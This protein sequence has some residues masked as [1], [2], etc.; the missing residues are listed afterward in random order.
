LISEHIFG[1]SQFADKV[2]TTPNFS[3]AVPYGSLL[4]KSINISYQQQQQAC[5]QHLERQS[6][7]SFLLNLMLRLFPSQI[8][9]LDYSSLQAHTH[10]HTHTHQFTFHE[11]FIIGDFPCHA[12]LC[13]AM[14]GCGSKLA[15][16]RN[17]KHLTMLIVLDSQ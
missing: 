12:L 17:V 7:A 15:V 6:F 3:P 8:I 14:M 4:G 16:K 1:V 5:Q 9:L 11:M 10:T 13:R 2:F